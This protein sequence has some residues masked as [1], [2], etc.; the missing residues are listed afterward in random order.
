MF[1]HQRV[2]A[3]VEFLSNGPSL[4]TQFAEL[5]GVSG[6][7]LDDLKALTELRNEIIH[8]AHLATGTPDN[9]PPELQTIK[10]RGVLQ[11]SKGPG[12]YLILGQM[13]SLR[14]LDWAKDVV[15]QLKTLVLQYHSHT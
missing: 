7:L 10:L 15:G 13:K 11:S 8:P 3:R 9:W 5:Y 4:P 14:L 1:A 6:P 2:A 12:D